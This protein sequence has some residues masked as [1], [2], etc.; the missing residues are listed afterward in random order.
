VIENHKHGDNAMNATEIKDGVYFIHPDGGAWSA[1]RF[2]NGKMVGSMEQSEADTHTAARDSWA[3]ITP[4]ESDID[5]DNDL[6]DAILAIAEPDS[7]PSMIVVSRPAPSYTLEMREDGGG[8]ETVDLDATDVDDARSEIS[9]ACEEW[10]KGGEYGDDGAAISVYWTLYEDGDEIDSGYETVEIEPNH[11]ALIKAAGGDTDCDHD[12][13]S[14]G[15]GGLSENPGVWSVGGTSMVF[16][17]HCTKCG[18]KRIEHHTGS[19]R[20]PGEHD[21]V[22]YAQPDSW[23]AECE[24]EECGCE[25]S[26]TMSEDDARDWVVGHDDSD[27]L[28]REELEAA[29]EALYGRKLS[30]DEA[31]ADDA[32][33]WSECVNACESD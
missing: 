7:D 29:W 32:T 5:V 18:L 21:T 27:D 2:R 26:K 33:L 13:T 12:W 14:E 19:Q 17:T 23:C 24:Q 8:D 3:G 1:V 31:E 16:H 22:E 10:I 28:D 4:S 11:D 25:R 20:N 6:A 9:D 30:S 15:E